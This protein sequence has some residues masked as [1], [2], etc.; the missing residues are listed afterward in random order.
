[1]AVPRQALRDLRSKY[2]E[3]LAMR[4]AEALP[5]EQ[6]PGDREVRARMRR[7]AE[8]FPGSL[9]EIDDL[10][11]REIALRIRALDAVL[12]SHRDAEPWMEALAL[13]HART[14]GILV[15]KRWLR[16]RKRID[17]ALQ[18]RFERELATLPFPED[19]R[20]WAAHL[21]TV[22]SPPR[23]RLLEAVFARLGRELQ[24]P[25]PEIRAL[26]FPRLS[27]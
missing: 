7:L 12:E 25:V 6:R 14:R 20:P 5:P 16:R 22:A 2:A 10:P 13:F 19:S 3:M 18:E 17:A 15:A 11:E 9:R 4:V 23:G 1:V 21:A 8:R 24:R 26:V 27:R